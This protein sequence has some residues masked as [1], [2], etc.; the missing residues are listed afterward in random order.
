V[1]CNV[2]TSPLE[3]HPLSELHRPTVA[4]SEPAPVALHEGGTMTPMLIRGVMTSV[5]LIAVC[6]AILIIQYAAPVLVPMVVSILLF[7][8]LDPVVDYLEHWRVPRMLASL[9][10]VVAL[11]G[12]VATATYLLWP[13]VEA[14]VTKVPEGA[15]QLRQSLAERHGA[16]AG[17]LEKVQEA[18]KA[19]DTA[20][21]EAG[22]PSP[23][24]P[25]VVRVEVQQSWKASDW[26]WSSGI[27]A[28][29][30]GGQAITVIFLTLF[31]LNEDDSFKRKLVRRMES[32]GSKRITV[33]IL[34]DIAAQVETFLWVQAITSAAVAVAT[35][36]SLWWLGVDQ[37]A[38]WGLLAGLLNIVPYFG[39]LIVTTILAAVGFIQFGSIQMAMLVAGVA[40]VITTLEGMILTPVLLS[41]AA[42]LNHVII[43]V[44][45]AFWS[46]VWGIPGMLLAVPILMVFK[47]I[48]DHVDGLQ[49]VSDFLGDDTDAK[50]R[51]LGVKNG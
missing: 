43:F 9:A 46:W 23:T 30:M 20:A 31:L 45:I 42:S 19:I 7:Y 25:G 34:N 3:T 29:G 27:G 50:S 35:G 28:I 33:Q 21:A 47:A 15:R 32:L 26:L 18:A 41:R 12:S 36:V 5:V 40:L 8:A 22:S 49:G 6:A 2:H 1:E 11:L 17:A 13:Q 51:V 24:A 44:A 48:A 14:V 38:V 10:V 4:S 37:P 16:E 39:P